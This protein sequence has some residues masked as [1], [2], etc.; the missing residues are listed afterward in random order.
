MGKE[1]ERI[2]L[3]MKHKVLW[4]VI[5]L[6]T[7]LLIVCGIYI[8]RH[9]K[10]YHDPGQPRRYYYGSRGGKYYIDA[11]GRKKYVRVKNRALSTVEEKE[12]ESGL[13]ESPKTSSL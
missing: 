10:C 4:F 7:L 12:K 8:A 6:E 11:A 2:G 5:L 13:M 1:I 9:F 3:R